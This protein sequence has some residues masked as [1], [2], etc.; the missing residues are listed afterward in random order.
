MQRFFIEQMAMYSAYHRDGRNKATHFVGVPAIALSLL[1]PM[2]MVRFA[3]IDSYSL[4]LA[5]LF[6]VSVMI[7]WIVL[8]P[9][10]GVVTAAIFVPAV[11]FADWIAQHG[12]ATAWSAFGILFVGG[13]IVQLVGHAFEGRK[14]ALVDNLLQVLIAPVFLV[15]EIAFAFGLRRPLHDAMLRRMPAYLPKSGAAAAAE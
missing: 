8:D 10:F 3:G 15:A 4:S 7:Y 5:T 14:P 13:W 6:A 12:G 9:P 1:I 11:W 2:A